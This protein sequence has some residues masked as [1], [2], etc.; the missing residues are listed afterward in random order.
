[1]SLTNLVKFGRDVRAEVNR[2][3]W[4]SWADTRRLTIM[5]F[6]LALLIALYLTGVDLLIGYALSVIF[7]FKF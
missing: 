7:G 4:P 3:T 1:M 2:I 6:I 5:V